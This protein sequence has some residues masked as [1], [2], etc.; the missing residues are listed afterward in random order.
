[1]NDINGILSRFQVLGIETQE[2][3]SLTFIPILLLKLPYRAQ[4]RWEKETQSLDEEKYGEK[5][6]SDLLDLFEEELKAQEN[7]QIQSDY[8]NKLR[9]NDKKSDKKKEK[10]KEKE[11]K[12]NPNAN[13][14]TQ[15][16]SQSQSQNSSKNKK[17]RPCLF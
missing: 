10:S 8:V 4:L 5:T 2:T 11:E 15:S 7:L 17:K 16:Q 3:H 1:M 13:F 14:S 6:Y 12:S 9:G